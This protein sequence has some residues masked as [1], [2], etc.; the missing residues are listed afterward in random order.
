[1]CDNCTPKRRLPPHT[2]GKPRAVCTRLSVARLARIYT[3][4][5]PV[6]VSNLAA[7]QSAGSDRLISLNLLNLISFP[8]AGDAG[9]GYY[10]RN[11]ANVRQ[12]QRCLSRE[13]FAKDGHEGVLRVFPS[14]FSSDAPACSCRQQGRALS[15]QEGKGEVV[16][17]H[18]ECFGKQHRSYQL[19]DRLLHKLRVQICSQSFC[20]PHYLPD[21]KTLPGPYWQ[22][23]QD[24]TLGATLI[25]PIINEH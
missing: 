9:T 23:A 21:R 12:S 16:F 4:T 25:L 19:Y 5:A 3:F 7:K 18:A 11:L 20:F 13:P 14:L 6:R 8:A 15:E 24:F 1:M 22:T 2:S 10:C 17:L